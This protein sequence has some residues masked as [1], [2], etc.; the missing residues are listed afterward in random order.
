M[1]GKAKVNRIHTTTIV[2]Y[3]SVARVWVV[4]VMLD[5]RVHAGVDVDRSQVSQMEVRLL[6]VWGTGEKK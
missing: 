1:M 4:T 2:P 5:V 6:G 3:H